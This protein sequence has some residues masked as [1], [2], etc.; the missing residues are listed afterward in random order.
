MNTLPKPI[1]AIIISFSFTNRA[2]CRRWRD[3][4]KYT[5][6]DD[7]FDQICARG[8]VSVLRMF[9]AQYPAQNWKYGFKIISVN[10]NLDLLKFVR[11]KYSRYDYF[12]LKK[13]CAHKQLH[14]VKYLI[15]K[16]AEV[17][18]II[19]RHAYKGGCAE[20]IKII[21][22]HHNG[23]SGDNIPFL[24]LMGAAAGGHENPVMSLLEIYG[25][26]VCGLY[27]LEAACKGGNLKIVLVL[28][29]LDTSIDHINNGLYYA[30]KKKRIEVVH[31][32][33]QNGANDWNLG[34]DGACESGCVELIQLMI[35]HGANNWNRGFKL[36]CSSGQVKAL[37]L[38]IQHGANEWE[39]GLFYA[40][41]YDKIDIVKEL[42]HLCPN[43]DCVKIARNHRSKK[44]LRF[45]NR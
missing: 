35:Q 38:M 2:V 45:F 24:A 44:V 6:D 40:C 27:A 18:N 3:T 36:A 31:F 20:I 16:G 14:I 10:G 17:C 12:V 11:N 33:I 8:T 26:S 23:I 4:V 25:K 19:I 41:I 5:F 43:V 42:I 34:L 9:L 37:Q 1:L 32:L 15:E 21:H 7:D 29:K 30:C 13:A 39:N 22:E 28:L